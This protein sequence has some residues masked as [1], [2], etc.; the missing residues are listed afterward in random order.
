MLL[1]DLPPYLAD[2]VYVQ[3]IIDAH[4]RELQRIEDT[5]SAI[6]LTMFPAN[7]DDTYGFL[8][9]WESLLGL[10][11]A[12]GGTLAER[13]NK[14]LAGLQ[15]RNA[16]AGSAWVALMSQALGT[17]PWTYEENDPGDYELTIR[18]PYEEGSYTASQVLV[19]A[20]QI[21]P[22]H[23]DVIP[24]YEEG[25]LVGISEIEIEPL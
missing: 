2:D 14:V 8:S 1:D 10:P 22:A 4:A 18:I 3:A 13:R 15:K 11:V 21:T 16:G 9:L 5:E 24:A 23:I 17:T 6:R 25:F 7:A 12:S 20:R 19:L